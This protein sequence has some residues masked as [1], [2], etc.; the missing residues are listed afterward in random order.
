MNFG[1]VE[2]ISVMQIKC[3]RLIPKGDE[4]RNES[5]QI[6]SELLVG[7]RGSLVRSRRHISSAWSKSFTYTRV[8]AYVRVRV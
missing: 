6:S 5:Y 8:L 2:A 3:S 7:I 4:R 1:T